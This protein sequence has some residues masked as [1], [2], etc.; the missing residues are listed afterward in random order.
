MNNDQATRVPTDEPG[1]GGEIELKLRGAPEALR[2][3]FE[4]AAINGR[5]R[6][7]GSSKRLENVYYDTADRRLRAQGLA[8]RVRKDGRK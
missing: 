6:G 2:S 4:G 3:L 8:F 5:A 1:A 7:R